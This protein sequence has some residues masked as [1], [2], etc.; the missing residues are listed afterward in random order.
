VVF[1]NGSNIKLPDWF[2]FGGFEIPATAALDQLKVAPA[3]FEVI[4]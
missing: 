3:T 2:T 1:V 4:V